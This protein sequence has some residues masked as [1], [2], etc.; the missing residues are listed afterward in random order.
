[1]VDGKDRTD[2][3][4]FHGCEKDLAGALSSHVEVRFILR[5]E[6]VGKDTLRI[7]NV[8]SFASFS[9]KTR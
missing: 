2:M 9:F 4:T 1:M 8:F 5:N 6:N 3:L 7:L